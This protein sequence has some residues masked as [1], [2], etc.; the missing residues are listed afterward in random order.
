MRH[1]ATRRFWSCYRS[2]PADVQS[3]ADR[4]YELLQ[5]DARHPSLQLKP[6]GQLWSVR[7]GLHYRAVALEEGNE[8][9]WVWIGSHAEYDLLLRRRR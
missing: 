6:I 2:L 7:V 4:C 9:V 1:R 3:L 5:Q 8:F